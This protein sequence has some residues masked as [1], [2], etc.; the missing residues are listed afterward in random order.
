MRSRHTPWSQHTL[1]S[2]CSEQLR[3]VFWNA[4]ADAAPH[5]LQISPGPQDYA[6]V[7]EK[8][9]LRNPM[10][11]L[12]LENSV[13][14]L[15]AGKATSVRQFMPV[16]APFESCLLRFSHTCSVPVLPLPLHVLLSSLVIICHIKTALFLTHTHTV[17]HV[18]LDAL[19][20]GAVQL[21][22]PPDHN[23]RLPRRRGGQLD[24]IDPLWLTAVIT[25]FAHYVALFF[26]CAVRMAAPPAANNLSLLTSRPFF[27]APAPRTAR[28]RRRC[29]C[30]TTRPAARWSSPPS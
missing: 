20:R 3:T 6:Y 8:Q 11:V 9:L 16:R 22:E 10:L 25:K 19:C 7:M 30:G 18:A 4:Y 17:L 28:S 2:I 21:C 29:S 15:L 27:T 5:T 26:T 13:R 14:R 12:L 24:Q 23:L 1:G